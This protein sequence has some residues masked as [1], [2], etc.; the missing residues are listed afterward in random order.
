MK[1]FF[2]LLITF[3]FFSF[4]IAQ[5]GKISGKILNNRN[6]P[7][8]GVTIKVTGS[9]AKAMATTNIEGRYNINLQ[10]G[11]KYSLSFSY[12]GYAEK[13]IDGITVSK[14]GTEE[15]L[16]IILEENKKVSTIDVSAPHAPI[17]K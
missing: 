9:S 16:D 3:F 2:L 17:V 4:A 1:N 10:V 15:I 14:S 12:I 6:E 8:V 5:N 13:V 11:N 7:L